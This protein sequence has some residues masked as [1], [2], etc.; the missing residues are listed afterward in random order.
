MAAFREDEKLN[1]YFLACRKIL[2]AMGRS[3]Y[4]R[5][6]DGGV[7]LK[8]PEGAFYLFPNFSNYMNKNVAGISVPENTP[9]DITV[10]G[11]VKNNAIDLLS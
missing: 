4:Y 9:P 11:R 1:A 2:R 5:L 3:L 7:L 6:R 8:E 10:K